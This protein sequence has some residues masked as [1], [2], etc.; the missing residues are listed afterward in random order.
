MKQNPQ[1]K[2]SVGASRYATSWKTQ[3]MKLADFLKKLENPKRTDEPLADYLSM[4]KPSQD[5]L[6]DVG[7][8]VGGVLTG[9]RRQAANASDR[10]LV[11]LDLDNIEPG[12]TEEVLEKVKA[13]GVAAAVYSTRKHSKQNPRLRV[14][15]PLV[16]ACTPDEYIPI[17]RKIAEYVGIDWCDPTTFEVTR[18][19]YW[20]SCS[21]DSEYIFEYFDNNL[22]D[23]DGILKLYADWKD[24]STYPTC[25]A[26]GRLI[27]KEKTKQADPLTKEGIVGAFC[28][29]YDIHSAI[30]EFIPESYVEAA[31]GR[32][33]Y[34]GGS[35]SGGVVVYDDKFIY[36]HHATDPCSG[37]CCNAYDMV[38]LHLFGDLDNESKEGTPV[39]KSP[40]YTAMNQFLLQREDFKGLF[41]TERVTAKEAF[42]DVVVSDQDGD[43]WM[44][45]LQLTDKGTIKVNTFNIKLILENDPELKGRY[46]YDEFAERLRTAGGLPWNKDKTDRDWAD[47]DDTCLRNHL[48]IKYDIVGKEKIYDAFNGAAEAH[49]VHPVR[50]YLDSLV[51]DNVPRVEKLLVDYL[52]AEDNEYTRE[53]MRITLA[54]AV[55]RIYEPG[56]KFDNMLIIKGGQG[57]GKSTLWGMLGKEWFSDSL[58]TF[59]GKE[60]VETLQGKW[61]LEAGELT[62]FSKQEMNAVKN[63]LSRRFDNYRPAYGRRS[64]EH[65]RSCI[66]VGTTNDQEFLRDQTGNRRFPVVDLEANEPT[67]NIFKELAG[68][69]DQIW[70]EAVALYKNGQTLYFDKAMEMLAEEARRLHIEEDPRI[71]M[72]REFLDRPLPDDW[73]DKNPEARRM[74]WALPES[75]RAGAS[76]KRERVCSQ[77][78][79]FECFGADVS[80]MTK[81]DSREI[82]EI[83]RSIKGWK[84]C[85]I[86]TTVYGRQ[87][88]FSATK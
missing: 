6:K 74:Y 67:K 14:I 64:I 46:Y 83:M 45:K 7:G 20:P 71:G 72:V 23:T 30:A 61:I 55:S 62:A 27:N 82:S 5:K 60:A 26:E 76:N 73:E 9:P 12:K 31:G 68:E 54:A 2:I 37:K 86:K 80:R 56:I 3:D 11:T 28:R 38:R 63:F 78:I 52:G 88:C 16:R 50:D 1:I 4:D 19:M 32:Y 53:V 48:S 22:A 58:V 17:A 8:F 69:V 40:S 39:C 84:N 70:A 10:Y 34:T 44:Q 47:I 75:S 57:I 15:V 42:K 85:G 81:K 24:V 36:S 35:T 33:T 21:K 41:I 13:L 25:S 43:A 65:K 87:R 59:T 79:W 18:L 77:E 66:I 29:M 49:K 51:W